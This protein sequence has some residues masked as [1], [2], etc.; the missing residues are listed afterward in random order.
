MEKEIVLILALVLISFGL[1]GALVV[2]TPIL[3]RN[4]KTI[5]IIE[6]KKLDYLEKGESPKVEFNPETFEVKIEKT[7]AIEE[8]NGKISYNS[9][10]GNLTFEFNDTQ[11]KVNGIYEDEEISATVQLYEANNVL[12]GQINENLF[13]CFPKNDK[14]YPILIKVEWE[15]WNNGIH[16]RFHLD[17]PS[18]AGTIES[19]LEMLWYYNGHYYD[20]YTTERFIW[21]KN[22]N[23]FGL[24][25]L[26]PAGDRKVTIG[27]NIKSDAG[28]EFYIYF[29]AWKSG[30]SQAHVTTARQK[31]TIE[32]GLFKLKNGEISLLG[33]DE[34]YLVDFN[35]T[36]NIQH[37]VFV[38]F[39]KLKAGR[40]T[41]ENGVAHYENNEATKNFLENTLYELIKNAGKKTLVK[42][43][44]YDA[45]IE[46]VIQKL[47]KKVTNNGLAKIYNYSKKEE[48]FLWVIADFIANALGIWPNDE[49]TSQ[50]FLG[51]ENYN[52]VLNGEDISIEN[53]QG[54]I[55]G[56]V[57]GELEGGKAFKRVEFASFNIAP[58]WGYEFCGNIVFKNGYLIISENKEG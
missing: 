4:E 17:S 25:E 7:R 57:A 3:V 18:F 19:W 20:S 37:D 44:N 15:Y 31:L 43:N 27:F 41:Y 5:K 8:N 29:Y 12:C 48:F 30:D 39:T 23:Y 11:V 35:V 53:P 52:I 33:Y 38:K 56:C 58:S 2:K 24:E 55:K 32:K 9:E 50:E 14:N 42:S 13:V 10:M 36:A 22:Y 6:E 45:Y 16:A 49:T 21:D 47:S 54:Y 34:L 40:G 51:G 28:K 1:F 26:G 46:I